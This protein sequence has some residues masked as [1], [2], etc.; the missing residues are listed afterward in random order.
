MK[1]MIKRVLASILLLLAVTPAFSSCA[2]NITTRD[3]TWAVGTVLPPAEAFFE[4]LPSGYSAR[5]AELYEFN[6][7]E[8]Y[9]IDVILVSALG[10][11]SRHRVKLTLVKDEEPPMLEGLRDFVAYINGGGISYLS[12]VT[13]RD[14]CDGEVSIDVNS[15]EVNLKKSGV[16]PVTYTATDAVGNRSV[17]NM[18]VTV[19]KQEVT[20]EMLFDELENVAKG[21]FQ[22]GMTTK[23]K[24]RAVYDFVRNNVAY[25]SI[26]DKSSWISAAY[27]GLT[28]GQGDCYTYFALSKAFFEYLEIENLDVERAQEAEIAAGGVRHFW[29]MVN[30]GT[31]EDPRWYHFDACL[32]KELPDPWG[33]LMTD[34]QLSRYASTPDSSKDKMT[35]FYYYDKDS[36]PASAKETLTAVD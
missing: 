7:F 27:E 8:T 13:A 20:R 32:I 21:I 2:S 23:E 28:T 19:M 36:V 9:S 15:S 4:E 30:L 35:Y 24:L 31:A 18:T 11:E 17:F 3:L 22:N 34:R 33:F 16:Y 14:N 5:Y 6:D 25:T 1:R 26:A 12:D 29:N 10:G